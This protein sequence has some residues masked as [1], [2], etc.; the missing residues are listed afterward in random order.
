MPSLLYQLD[1]SIVATNDA[2]ETL[3]ISAGPSADQEAAFLAHFGPRDIQP[4]PPTPEDQLK[5]IAALLVKKGIATDAEIKAAT[6]IDT[7]T[8]AADQGA[9]SVKPG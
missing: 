1:G 5:A 4:D 3:K 6:A 8:I 9:L 2:G 7:A